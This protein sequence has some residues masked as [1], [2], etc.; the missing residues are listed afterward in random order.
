MTE[1]E[2]DSNDLSVSQGDTLTVENDGL[3]GTIDVK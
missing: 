3:I 1:H 2:F